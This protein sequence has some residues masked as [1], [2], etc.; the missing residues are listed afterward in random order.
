MQP[1][2]TNQTREQVRMYVCVCVWLVQ[3][4]G[5]VVRPTLSRETC[6]LRERRK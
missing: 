5:G 2:A 6:L 4:I 3:G 1:V